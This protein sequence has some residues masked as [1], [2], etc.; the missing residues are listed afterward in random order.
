MGIGFLQGFPL[1]NEEIGDILGKSIGLEKLDRI[2]Q[3]D[4]AGNI[5]I[6]NLYRNGQFPEGISVNIGDT[7]VK[8]LSEAEVAAMGA[9]QALHSR[10]GLH[11]EKEKVYP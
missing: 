6:P 7:P 11:S 10:Q 3:K 8:I 4:E 2:F 1:S 5:A 9:D